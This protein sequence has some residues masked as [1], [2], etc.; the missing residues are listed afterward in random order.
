MR[1]NELTTKRWRVIKTEI[2]DKS[3]VWQQEHNYDD[4][5]KDYKPRLEVNFITANM[6]TIDDM[7]I[8]NGYITTRY[9][10][11]QQ[12]TRIVAVDAPSQDITYLYDNVYLHNSLQP[13]FQNCS[14]WYKLEFM[15]YSHNIYLTQFDD[16]TATPPHMRF[17][18]QSI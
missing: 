7:T 17:I 16:S 3:G 8:M 10:N 9:N 5:I 15:P 13:F 14:Y 1:L 18:L 11:T 2:Y 12:R 4:A 6:T